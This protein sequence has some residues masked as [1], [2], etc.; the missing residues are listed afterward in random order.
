MVENFKTKVILF[1]IDMSVKRKWVNK[2][3]IGFNKRI[4]V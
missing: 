4:S 2:Y 1:A 3:I